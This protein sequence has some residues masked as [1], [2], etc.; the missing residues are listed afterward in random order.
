[1]ANQP[2][3]NTVTASFTMPEALLAA[4]KAKARRE[5]TNQSDIIRRALM[6]SRS[7]SERAEVLAANESGH[8]PAHQPDNL[9]FSEESNSKVN[10]AASKALKMA[11]A[12]VKKKAAK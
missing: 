2:A 1:M 7:P 5:M 8:Y 9:V 4:V 12:S 11:V 10:A 3:E 6:N